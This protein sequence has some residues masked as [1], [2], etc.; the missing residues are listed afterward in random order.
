[1][2]R[3]I[4]NCALLSLLTLFFASLAVHANDSVA[5]TGELKQWHKVTL[6]LDGPFAK[7]RDTEPNPF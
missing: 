7:E 3:I 4:P 5:I 1:M 2:N 6:T